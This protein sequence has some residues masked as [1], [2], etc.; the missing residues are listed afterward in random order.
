MRRGHLKIITGLKYINIVVSLGLLMFFCFLNIPAVLENI[1]A[2]LENKPSILEN[3][4]TILKNEQVFTNNQ[5]LYLICIDWQ[6][7]ENFGL[8][9]IF[10][11][12]LGL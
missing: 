1:P 9:Y 8:N 5:F 10:L 3:K 6:F 12:K 7:L 4:P 2:V 11:E